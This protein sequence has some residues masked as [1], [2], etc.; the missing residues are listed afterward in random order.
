MGHEME[1]RQCR[2]ICNDGK[3]SNVHMPWIRG[4][5]TH[6]ELWMY[7]LCPNASNH[8]DICQFSNL[9]VKAVLLDEILMNPEHPNVKEMVLKFETKSLRDTRGIKF[10]ACC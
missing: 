3:N 1:R 4:R 7:S 8:P 5:G 10:T 6:S 9:K 2:T